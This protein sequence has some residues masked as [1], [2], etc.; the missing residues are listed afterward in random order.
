[1]QHGVGAPPPSDNHHHIHEYISIEDEFYKIYNNKIN[2]INEPVFIPSGKSLIINEGSRL[3][4]GIDG[5]LHIE[6]DLIIE[7]TKNLPVIFEAQNIYIPWKGIYVK[8][9]SNNR[10]QVKITHARFKNIGNYPIG[11]MFDKKFTGSITLINSDASIDNVI[12]EN[13]S[14]EDAINAIKSSLLIQNTNVIKSYSDGIDLDFCNA[15]IINSKFIDSKGD[16][17]D[18]SNSLIVLNDSEF[19]NNGDKGLSIGEKSYA[20]IVNCKFI[21]NNIGI[22]NKDQSSVSAID[23]YFNNNIIA[24]ASYIKKPYFGKPILESNNNKY[25]SNI[26]DYK[27]LG[28][29]D[30]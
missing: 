9:Q 24:V 3:I 12:I 20:E 25:T 17:L 2:Y 6:G 21:N 8:G 30:Y 22:A 28:F 14:S 29:Y 18:I 26:N 4:F 15:N 7:G 16:G 27:W 11:S 19:Y 23:S 1:M 13:S 5:G 10:S